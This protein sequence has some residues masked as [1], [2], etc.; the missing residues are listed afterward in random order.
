MPLGACP[1]KSAAWPGQLTLGEF[2]LQGP[3]PEVG[4]HGGPLSPVELAPWEEIDPTVTLQLLTRNRH[5]LEPWEPS[6]EPD[7]Y[8][9]ESHRSRLAL[10]AA[11]RL[12]GRE[13]GYGV[14]LRG[15]TVVVGACTLSGIER[16]PFQSCH[17]GYWIAAEHNN[18]GYAQ[19]AIRLI[20]ASAFGELGL[21]RVEAAVMPR[22]LA[23]RRVLVKSFFRE[24][25]LALRYLQ[26]RGSWEDHLI[27]ART[28]ED[29]G[30]DVDS[31]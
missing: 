31:L 25:G 23:S 3:A 17:L 5:H 15:T 20:L 14:T 18:R 7:F 16:G 13:A 8:S 30:F 2:G 26:I 10:A 21:H 12:A 27:F 19:A 28:I 9:P 1:F 24:E 6:R 29:P 11:S 22:N 4:W